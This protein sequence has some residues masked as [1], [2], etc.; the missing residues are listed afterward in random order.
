[1]QGE[2]AD[3][4]PATE[5]AEPAA[6]S[7]PAKPTPSGGGGGGGKLTPTGS[8]LRV[9]QT[10]VVAGS[11]GTTIVFPSPLVLA[12][13]AHSGNADLVSFVTDRLL[14]SAGDDQQIKLWNAADGQPWKQF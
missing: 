2:P 9:G 4:A 11:D 8:T 7:T 5:A 13:P 10:A 1:M 14:I 12:I 3:V 6:A